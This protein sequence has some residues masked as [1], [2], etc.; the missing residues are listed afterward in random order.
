MAN[1]WPAKGE[2]AVQRQSRGMY[3]KTSICSPPYK[4]P[5]GA[6]MIGF[7]LHNKHPVTELD[8]LQDFANQEQASVLSMLN[9]KRNPDKRKV[10]KLSPLNVQEYDE[11][12]DNRILEREM[13]KTKK[14]MKEALYQLSRLVE[15][16]N[17]LHK[18]IQGGDPTGFPHVFDL[19]PDIPQY[20]RI[21][22]KVEYAAP[23]IIN[24]K[25]LGAPKMQQ[26]EIDDLVIYGSFKDKDPS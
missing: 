24:M 14:H 22:C 17:S 25:D 21:E 16:E 11:I 23:I 1:E 20:L 13:N 6:N 15:D 18:V 5:T 3:S 26:D 10:S 4:R 8:S 2:F 12:R 19:Y 7:N 9:A